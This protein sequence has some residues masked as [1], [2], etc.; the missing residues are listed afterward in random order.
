MF[1]VPGSGT[2]IKGLGAGECFVM[3]GLC[4]LSGWFCLGAFFLR[5]SFTVPFFDQLF[6]FLQGIVYVTFNKEM[7]K[8]VLL[9]MRSAGCICVHAS[10]SS[11]LQNI[12]CESKG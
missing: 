7:L 10:G 3:V 2:G 11:R 9:F 1:V 5:G 6:S 4:F 12:Y 8:H